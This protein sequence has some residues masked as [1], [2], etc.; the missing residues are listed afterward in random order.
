[1]AYIPGTE[2]DDTLNGSD[3]RDQILGFGGNDRLFGVGGDDVIQGGAGDDRLEGGEGNDGLWGDAGRDELYGGAGDD[4]LHA[5]IG[6]D[7]LD[8]GAGIDTVSYA[9]APGRAWADLNL[10]RGGGDEPYYPPRTFDTYS[11]IENIDGSAFDDSFIGSEEANVLRGGGG[12]DFLTGEGGNDTLDGGTG[13]DR[14]EGHD[15]D[16]FLDGG[17][18]GDKMWGGT[19]NDTYFIDSTD[20]RVDEA[21]YGGTAP[22]GIDTVRSSYSISLS[23]ETI[24]KGDIESLTLI[25]SG[26][27]NGSGNDLANVVTGNTGANSLDGRAGDDTLAGGFGNDTL[28]GGDGNDSFLFNTALNAAS[29][30]DK[31]N[32][33]LVS[34]DTIW[35]DNAVF[36]ELATPGALDDDPFYI[37]TAAHDTNDRVIYD[38]TTGSLT[39]DANGDA[40][41]GFTGFAVLDAGLA[42][43]NSDFLVV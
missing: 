22:D 31:I 43:T 34:D 23:N 15:G 18:G 21:D 28:V 14:L 24:F 39:Y 7:H 11:G 19:G 29:D 26:N 32:D 40:A 2:N 30:V 17:A 25:G 5:G 8:G 37:G 3:G 36:T 42:L 41:G 9:D 33:F 16:D 1:M 4:T 10:G 38:P 12:N 13:R 6:G 35:L 27:L 20:D